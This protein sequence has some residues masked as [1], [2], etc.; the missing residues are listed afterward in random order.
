MSVCV[1]LS[2]HI[3][4]CVPD[5]SAACKLFED[6]CV[7]FVKKPK[8]GEFFFV[9]H[10]SASLSRSLILNSNFHLCENLFNIPAEV[11]NLSLADVSFHQQV[12]LWVRAG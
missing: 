9:G 5:L 10:E 12:A 4:I 2:G 6:Q 3:G 11:F 8:S 7:K 1:C